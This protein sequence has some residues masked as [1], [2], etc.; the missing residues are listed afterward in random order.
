MTRFVVI[1]F[2][3]AAGCGTVIAETPVNPAPRPMPPRADTSVEVYTSAAPARPHVDVSYLEAS[4][5]TYSY[6]DTATMLGKLRS[7]AAE[8]GCDAIVVAGLTNATFDHRSLKG[9]VATCIAYTDIAMS[10]AAL[11]AACVEQ[12]YAIYLRIKASDD[13][14]ERRRLVATAPH[15]D[16]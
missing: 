2:G 9:I 15:C 16:G 6:D 4:Q 5:D 7:H 12:R 8:L 13:R 14:D 3:I 1:A 10:P 11:H